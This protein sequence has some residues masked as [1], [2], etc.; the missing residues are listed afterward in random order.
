MF[1]TLSL[2]FVCLYFRM[3]TFKC[4]TME[5]IEAEKSLIEKNVVS[6][7]AMYSFILL[8]TWLTK[9]YHI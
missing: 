6:L 8:E 1:S 7:L 3:G 9:L 2:G 5:E 4:A